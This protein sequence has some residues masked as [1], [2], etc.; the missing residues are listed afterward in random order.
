MSIQKVWKRSRTHQGKG[1][2]KTWTFMSHHSLRW[3]LQDNKSVHNR[4]DEIFVP[5]KVPRYETDDIIN[6]MSLHLF[7]TKPVVMK[8]LNVVSK[9]TIGLSYLLMVSCQHHLSVRENRFCIR[10]IF[11]LLFNEQANPSSQPEAI[12]WC[13]CVYLHNF[14]LSMNVTCR[15]TKGLREPLISYSNQLVLFVCFES[16]ISIRWKR[17]LIPHSS[18]AWVR[19]KWIMWTK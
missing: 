2:Q 17:V 16:L 14:R 13:L 6:S 5:N 7:N 3:P 8:T 15:V 10:D 19:V 9:N 1:Q 4:Q 18:G 12:T 11:F